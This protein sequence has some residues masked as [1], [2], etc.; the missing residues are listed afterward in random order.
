MKDNKGTVSFEII[1]VLIIILLIIGIISNL[2]TNSNEKI[3]NTIEKEH[4]EKLTCELCDNLINNPRNP[5]NWEKLSNF[6]NVI[7]GLAILGEDNKTLANSVSYDKLVI[8]KENYDELIDRRLFK[9]QMKSSIVIYPFKKSIPAIF[10]GSENYGET[11]FSISRFVKCDFFKKYT[12]INFE[13]SN[14][15]CN[16]NHDNNFTCGY[17][18]VFK[19]D[20]KYNDYYL[21][22][23]DDLINKNI[24]WAVD[25]TKKQS[26][27]YNSIKYNKIYLN[28]ILSNEFEEENECIFFLHFKE[29]NTLKILLIK[30]PKEFNKNYL[31][32]D[33]FV[34]NDCKIILRCWY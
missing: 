19:S 9:N 3:I 15:S 23:D 11:V 14:S 1:I 30:V 6:N 31:N 29:K 27:D 7:P 21:L 4:V 8:L 5:I 24:Y 34:L 28:D 13:N 16:Q 25:N 12:I 18:K 26:N 17:F 10:L 22:T 33:Y 20:L 32:Y 2:T